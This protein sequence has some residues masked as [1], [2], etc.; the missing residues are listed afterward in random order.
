MWR[1]RRIITIPS[2][3]T[4]GSEYTASVPFEVQGCE[5]H[6]NGRGESVDTVG[7]LSHKDGSGVWA[8]NGQFCV[9]SASQHNAA[10]ASSRCGSAAEAV[11]VINGVGAVV[12][13]ATASTSWDGSTGIIT[14]T[15]TTAFTQGLTILVVANGGLSTGCHA[16]N[17]FFTGSVT[18]DGMAGAPDALMLFSRFN[19]SGNH[20][21]V[22]D[23]SFMRGV[24]ARAPGGGTLQAVA[25][26]GSD[27]TQDEMRAYRWASAEKAY[28]MES[29]SVAGTVYARGEISEWTEDGFTLLTDV[30]S[31][32][33][34]VIG[35][36][37]IGC[38]ATVVTGET[39]TTMD[40]IEFAPGWEP[41]GG[42]VIS[43]AA[44]LPGNSTLQQDDVRSIGVFDH[45]LDQAA[46]GLLDLYGTAESQ[47]ATALRTNDV[48]VRTH[49][50]IGDAPVVGGAMQVSSL[51]PESTQF[52]MS[53]P[54]IDAEP[55]WFA[56]L[57]LGPHGDGGDPPEAAITAPHGR[58][59]TT[60]PVGAQIQLTGTLTDAEDEPDPVGSWSTDD[61]EIATVSG[62]GLVTAIAEGSTTIR[63]GG[64]DSAGMSASASHPVV[65]SNAPGEGAGA[66]GP[67]LLIQTLGGLR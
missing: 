52:V 36:A 42:M 15:V 41:A 18:I 43:H 22:P 12:G 11:Q 57:L 44:V 64:T 28:A 3:A 20:N 35:L 33:G 67:R 17:A 37:F 34:Q 59:R 48:Y 54:E 62:S 8:P 2:G 47:V 32:N 65:V 63:F 61:A 14:L 4:I 27:A 26:G 29:A 53:V 60:L 30:G 9:F 5:F 66:H 49:A 21:T 51:A 23:S 58:G 31:Q 46:V 24:A 38:A 13:A 39:G 40:P 19:T 25:F 7:A 1:A 45:G 6:F 10:T 50:E 55:R 56:A 16:F